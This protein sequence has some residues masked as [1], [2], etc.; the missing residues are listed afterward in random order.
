MKNQSPA[1]GCGIQALLDA[2]EPN[3]PIAQSPHHFNKMP[4]RTTQAI[5]FPDYNDVTLPRVVQG[6]IQSG[7][8]RLGTTS[9]IGK[10]S[11]FITTCLD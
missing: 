3:A 2:F 6:F 11:F 4:Q 8:S 9:N 1:A 10:N 7:S 5:K